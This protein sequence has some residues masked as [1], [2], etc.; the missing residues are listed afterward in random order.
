MAQ[1]QERTGRPSKGDRRVLY[2]RVPREIA[3]RV[4]ADAD[5]LQLGL[6]D[7]VANALAHY[8]GMPPVA[9]PRTEQQ[10]QLTA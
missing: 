5:R 6:S 9:A 10:M 2:S 8:Y 7:I 3:D 1:R 4:E